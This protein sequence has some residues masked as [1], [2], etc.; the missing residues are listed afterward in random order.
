MLDGQTMCP[1]KLDL[2]CRKGNHRKLNSSASA[3]VILIKFAII[4]I[5]RCYLMWQNISFF[6]KDAFLNNFN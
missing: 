5:R 4:E 1:I 6:V 2:I 3:W